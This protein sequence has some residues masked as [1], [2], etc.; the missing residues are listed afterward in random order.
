MPS[1]SN[2]SVENFFQLDSNAKTEFR[3]IWS[4]LILRNLF[5][6]RTI[7]SLVLAI[8]STW[9]LYS[10]PF[11]Q[12]ESFLYD[13]RFRL[14]PD[15]GKSKYVSI[16]NVDKEQMATRGLP[17]PKEI[18]TA[19]EAISAS[20]PKFIL[21]DL[22]WARLKG[23][24][25]EKKELADFMGTVGN[26]IILINDS[27]SAEE[28]IVLHAPPPFDKLRSMWG[29]KTQDGAV[30][31]RDKVTRRIVIS[32]LGLYSV[33]PII[34]SHFNPDIV[35][36]KNI[37]GIFEFLDAKQSLID[38]RRP[39]HFPTITFYSLV[40]NPY[41]NYD[42][43]DRAVIL[44]YV[45]D[46]TLAQYIQPV[47]SRELLDFPLY[48]MHAV[49]LDTLIRNHS[50][51]QV[52]DW[53]HIF[54]IF[55]FS[56]LGSF[57]VL[58]MRV[59]WG[60]VSMMTV[61]VFYLLAAFVL[62]ALFKLWIPI[63]TVCLG[64]GA[65][66]YL[67]LPFQLALERRRSWEFQ[68][69][70]RI[71]GQVEELK[72]NFISMMSHDLKT[73]I[74]RIKGMTDI[75]HTDS[76]KLDERQQQAIRL[77]RNSSDDLLKFF[78]SIL[79]YSNMESGGV[80]LRL[81]TK[82]ITHVVETVIEQC[83]FMAQQKAI[84]IE[85]DYEPLFPIQIDPQLIQQVITNLVENSIKYS[86]E[87]SRIGIHVFERDEMVIVEVQDNGGG[88]APDDLPHLFDKFFRSKNVKSSPIKGSGLGL[89]LAKYFVELHKGKISVRSTYGEGSTFTVELPMNA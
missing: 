49:M 86:P 14:I 4:H 26:L 12:F 18:R 53:L 38:Y 71:L 83:R 78:E 17:N 28:H 45:G 82:D 21:I 41:F 51:L 77:I 5:K 67:P 7:L 10:F 76:S 23:S 22:P 87:G 9:I 44:G 16:V 33:Y 75:I 1:D 69:K 43:R 55:V 39:S 11:Y 52:P 60:L 74:A 37:R 59:S 66:Y 2:F 34:A 50:V 72:S 84:Q 13:L 81:Q 35:N 25:K 62:F 36:P 30:L 68:E 20:R 15:I 42:F 65:C 58:Y 48:Y 64:L 70:N 80:Q 73:P 40:D 27:P 61:N 57:F 3:K 89:Y 29:L 88:I 8:C 46:D 54:L 31:A 19:I 47:Y 63:T 85:F 6:P 32:H 24:A 56:L 79:S